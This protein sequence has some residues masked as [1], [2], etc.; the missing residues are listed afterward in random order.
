MSVRFSASAVVP[1]LKDEWGISSTGA[2]TLTGAVQIGFVVGA[3]LSALL[4]LPDRVSPRLVISAAA[5]GA[6]VSNAGVA[7]FADGLEVAL[8]L[9]FATGFFLAGVYA[10]GLALISGWFRT[11]LGLALGVVV[12]ALT[13][14]SGAPHLITAFGTPDWQWVL[15][16]GSALALVA[17]G[18]AL[19]TRDGPY[20]APAPPLQLS[21]AF[22]LFANRPMRL[23]NFGYFGH[24]WELY[25]VWAWLPVYLAASIGAGSG[26][27]VLAFAAIGVAGAI[28]AVSGGLIADRIGRT[29]T[30]IGM[31]AISGSAIIGSAV[32]FEAHPAAV[33]VLALVWGYSVIGDSGQF[34]AAVGELAD[35]AHVGTAITVQMAVGFLITIFSIQ[36]VGTMAD[37]VGWRW[38]F[39]VL[40]IG[41]ILGIWAMWCLRHD[42]AAGHLAG[43]AR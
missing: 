29:A 1:Q 17:S 38:A 41:P 13:L 40:L 28:G 22:K 31:L 20:R 33:A 19:L 16:V 11:H 39:L 8:P 32:L 35:R 30:T 24:M 26:S 4:S 36:L 7:L 6:A 21:Y 23:A 3:V 43:G 37:L 42:E 9:R 14:G 5:L 10:P 12:G 2:A 18:L 27:A 15:L 34:S 25:G